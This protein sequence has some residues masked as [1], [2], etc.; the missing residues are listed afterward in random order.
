MLEQ[1]SNH[2]KNLEDI[3]YKKNIWLSSN[4]KNKKNFELSE[5]I[6]LISWE[7][8]NLNGMVIK[9]LSNSNDG[10]FLFDWLDG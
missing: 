10:T 6:R 3:E 5:N 1:L 9:I 4:I 8:E 7:N 2:I